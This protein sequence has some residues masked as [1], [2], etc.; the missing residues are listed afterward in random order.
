M[1]DAPKMVSAFA[2]DG[3]PIELPASEAAA[4]EHRS[5][6]QGHVMSPA[7]EARARHEIDLQKKLGGI[8]GYVAPGLAGAARGLTFG[9][10]DIALSSSPEMRQRL[11]DYEEYSPGA[12]KAAEVAGMVG[13]AMLGVG[14]AGTLGRAG[15][16]LEGGIVEGIGAESALGRVA[17]KGLGGAAAGAFENGAYEAGRAASD[18]AIH[19]E[20]LTGEK[21][22]AATTHGALFGGA[23]GGV[24]GSLGGLAGET[25]G[26]ARKPSLSDV[27]MPAEP[28]GP[29]APKGSLADELHKA[30]DVKTIKALGGSAGDIR[31]LE[32]NVPGGYRRVAQDIRA[33]VEATT[34]KS[35]GHQS[36]EALHEYA[37]KRVDELGEK[38]GEM[39]EK[40]D[41]A[42]SGVA[43]RPAEF[44]AQVEKQLIDPHVIQTPTGPVALPG[45]EKQ[46][47]AVSTWAK[48]VREA[49]ADRAP[50]F[51]EWQKMRVALDKQVFEGVRSASP[52]VEALRQMRGILEGELETAGEQAA[53]SMDSSFQA[54]YKA[55]KSLY[56]SVK[57]AQELTT[58]GVSRDLVNNSTGLTTRLAAMAGTS[59]GAGLG[60]PV[61]AMLGG[62]A[63]GAIGQVI[64]RR[65]DVLAADLL[66][67]A[68][69][70][71]GANRVAGRVTAELEQG[72]KRLVGN[73]NHIPA[74]AESGVRAAS[75]PLG[76]KSTGSQR[77]N[78]SKVSEM[79][80]RAAANPMGTA[81]RVSRAV[82]HLA[83]H[84]PGTANAAIQTTLRGV[85]FLFSKLPPSR[86][87]PYSIQP[88]LQGRSRASDA[89]V[90]RFM[91]YAQ[92]VDDPMIVL[93]E[94]RSGTLT[95]DHVEAVQAVYPKL[96]D[97]IR[98]SVFQSLVDSKTKLPYSRLIQ[99]GILLDI[100]TDKTL[101]PEFIRAVQATYLI[102]NQAG[103]ESP[104]PTGTFPNL[105][106][107]LQTATQSAGEAAE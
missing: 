55:T 38:L 80:T 14:P 45:F 83:D 104:P 15:R 10:S 58:R 92:A 99:L 68:A 47:E 21:L 28:V 39:I 2:P 76:V 52:T 4:L 24:L 72:V 35:I 100:P 70:L 78:F 43:P 49:F 6:G 71:A 62:A 59:V 17:A 31:T 75:A 42:P 19:D 96:Y 50:T 26:H 25:L 56:Q 65:G 46:I 54:E 60:G 101:S 73:T 67:R 64:Q 77:G 106:G 97:E 82:G 95:R 40:L 9:L 107:S 84:S 53:Q 34:G 81:D 44:V 98:G 86:E 18:S 94:A 105:A 12:S 91:R 3:T 88:H 79:V 48:N 102:A 69:T 33:D 1:A 29:A 8:E 93:R 22:V 36:R 90:S 27:E 51:R 61:G 103:A 85:D 5:G 13:G 63:G 16:A 23:V 20:P 37:T 66:S 32:A 87:D 89:E 11:Q 30:S 57:K 74:A 41:E 7:E